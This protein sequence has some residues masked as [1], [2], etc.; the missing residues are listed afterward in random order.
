MANLW[1]TNDSKSWLF[2]GE[3]D[4]LGTVGTTLSLFWTFPAPVV[5]IRG[6]PIAVAA[7]KVLMHRDIRLPV[8]A[9]S[10]TSES[11]RLLWM[12]KTH[13]I[14]TVVT[15]YDPAEGLL[16]RSVL[17][18]YYLRLQGSH[19]ANEAFYCAVRWCW[20]GVG[21]LALHASGC[22]KPWRHHSHFTVTTKVASAD[23]WHVLARSAWTGRKKAA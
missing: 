11:P 16:T 17:L 9:R 8:W 5:G 10:V 13:Y 23:L 12:S 15:P 18:W 2:W 21:G 14:C 19:A 1:L 7:H 6:D 20:G 3:P 22:L 4:R